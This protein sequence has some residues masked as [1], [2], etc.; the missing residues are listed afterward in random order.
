VLALAPRH[1]E[2]GDARTVGRREANALYHPSG[3]GKR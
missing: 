2:D 1:N 3:F